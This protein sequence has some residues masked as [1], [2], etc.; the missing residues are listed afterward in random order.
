MDNKKW[1]RPKS[2]TAITRYGSDY[3]ML[4]NKNPFTIPISNFKMK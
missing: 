4:Y 1:N 3:Q 2:S